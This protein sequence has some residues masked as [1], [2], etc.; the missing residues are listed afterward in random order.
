MATL[1]EHIAQMLEE[2]ARN[3]ELRSAPSYGKPLAPD[4]GYDETPD[5]L[6]MPFKILKDAGVAPPEVELF[7]QV[8]ALKAELAG[9]ADPAGR[10][11]LQQRISELQQ[12][13]ALRLE[14]LRA[15]GSL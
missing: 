3:G 5:A 8:G 13:I 14:R 2:A 10:Q 7:R 9:L 15:S 4:V 12:L 1:D 6:K 11:K